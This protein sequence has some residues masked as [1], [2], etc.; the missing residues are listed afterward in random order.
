MN[1]PNS[2]ATAEP[3]L[4]SLPPRPTTYWLV[5][6]AT[7]NA[8]YHADPACEGLG[9]PV[10][11]AEDN[12]E[13]VRSLLISVDTTTVDEL[14]PDRRLCRMCALR[15]ATI[16]VLSTPPAD[17][18]DVTATISA[19]APGSA[20]SQ[21]A[22]RRLREI[23]EATGLNVVIGGTGSAV[24][25]GVVPVAALDFLE[26]HFDISLPPPTVELNDGLV[27]TAWTLARKVTDTEWEI[28]AAT[29]I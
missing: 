2:Q 7:P 13:D 25:Y 19:S 4:G 21:S 24:L 10:A 20:P 6:R 18:R 23:G 5:P 22:A 8:R 26:L 3:A 12:G 17:G 29:Q 28:A 16:R 27:L 15:D 11:W 1:P 14:H 9:W